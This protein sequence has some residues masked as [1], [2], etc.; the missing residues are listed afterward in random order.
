MLCSTKCQSSS[1]T[2]PWK[3]ETP[4]PLDDDQSLNMYRPSDRGYERFIVRAAPIA[5]EEILPWGDWGMSS[6]GISHILRDAFT[7]IYDLSSDEKQILTF[8]EQNPYLVNLLLEGYAFIRPYFPDS[9][10]SLEL[11]RDP[12][13]EENDELV[14]FVST[15]LEVDD[16]LRRL[17]AFEELWWLRN[18]HRGHMKLGFDLVFE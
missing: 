7:L 2:E 3:W 17:E 18:I 5:G 8:L 10:I 9:R 11:N 16:A 12:D 1:S 13:A 6:F 15:T 14:V 4:F